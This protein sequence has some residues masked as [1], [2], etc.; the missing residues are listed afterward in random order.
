VTASLAEAR[1][2][3]PGARRLRVNAAVSALAVAAL[4]VAAFGSGVGTVLVVFGAWAVVSGAIQ[5]VGALRRRRA[6]TRETPMIV[7]GTISAIAGVSFIAAGGGD[8]PSVMPLAGYAAFGAL[9]FLV[10][11]YRGRRAA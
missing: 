4:A 5:L 9:L 6:G 2:G 7:S 3:G 1:R 10:W 8:H 11:A